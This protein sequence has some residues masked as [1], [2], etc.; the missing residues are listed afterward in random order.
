MAETEVGME[1]VVR[2][3]QNKKAPLLMTDTEVGMEMVVRE[4][5]YSKTL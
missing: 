2:E 4:W 5:Q 3:E 1:M